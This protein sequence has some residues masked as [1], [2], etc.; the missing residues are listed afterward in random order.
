MLEAFDN[1]YRL[2]VDLWAETALARISDHGWSLLDRLDSGVG[3]EDMRQIIS[4]AANADS[5]ND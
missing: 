1:I 4:D 5:V 3:L 2:R